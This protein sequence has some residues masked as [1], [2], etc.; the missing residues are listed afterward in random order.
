MD[1]PAD[2]D[3]PVQSQIKDRWSP[4]AFADK[5][6]TADTLRSLLEAARWSASCFNDQPWRFIIAMKSDK[7]RFDEM[8]GCLVEVN[9]QWAKRAQVLLLAACET[10]FAHNGKPNNHCAYDTGAA[11]AQFTFEATSRGLAVHQMAGFLKDKAVETFKIPDSVKPLAAIALGYPGTPDVL[12]DKLK[13]R[14]VAPRKRKPQ[15]DFVFHGAWKNS[16]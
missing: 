8:L 16:L 13:E 7:E 6:I 12:S 14:E 4:L 1:K 2:V 9:Q 3:F 15:K 10:N 11:V 5:E